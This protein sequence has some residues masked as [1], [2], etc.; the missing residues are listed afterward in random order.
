MPAR[1]DEPMG[2]APPA[3]AVCMALA[4]QPTPSSGADCWDFGAIRFQA[5]QVR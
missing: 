1:H 5:E 3:C 4:G 2:V